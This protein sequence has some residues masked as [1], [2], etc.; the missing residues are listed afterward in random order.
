[1][2][3]IILLAHKAAQSPDRHRVGIDF[4]FRVFR[5]YLVHISPLL[6]NLLKVPAL[7]AGTYSH[8]SEM[9]QSYLP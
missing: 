9:D 5:I 7:A 6:F 1:M 3:K 4:V 2:F 8:F